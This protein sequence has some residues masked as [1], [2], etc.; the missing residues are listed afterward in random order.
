MDRVPET[1]RPAPPA[2]SARSTFWAAG[3]IST[4]TGA[5]R[6]SRELERLDLG[7]LRCAVRRRHEKTTL[8]P[9]ES[10]APLPRPAEGH[11]AEPAPPAASQAFERG[12][13]AFLIVA[14]G[15][16]TRLGFDHPKGM[17]EVGPVS[18]A[19]AVPDPRREGPRPRAGASGTPFPLLIM[20][21]PATHDETVAFFEEKN[22]SACRRRRSSSSSRGRCRRSIWRP[23]SC[24]WKNR[25][26]CS[27][28]PTATAAR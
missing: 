10:I 6:S 12:E 5:A 23:A 24:W 4:P 28:A 14:G 2:A 25:A 3:T 19:D 18:E 17:F 27:S 13:I 20:T 16:G 1:H 9:A 11:D 22:C 8:P 7:E 15:Q 21:S 26:G